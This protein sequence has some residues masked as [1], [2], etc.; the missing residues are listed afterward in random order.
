MNI[1]EEIIAYKKNEVAQQKTAMRVEQLE[2]FGFFS[3]PCLSLKAS[4]LDKNKTGII[5]EFKRRSPSKGIINDNADVFEVTRAYTAAGASG[6]SVLTDNK[7]FGGSTDDL[8]KARV[9]GIP[10]LRKD[11]MIDEYQLVEAKALGA[12]VILLIAACLSPE[13]V[14]E[15]ATRAKQ[16]GMEVLLEIHAEEELDHLC[17]E[18]DMVGV[19]NRNLKTFTVDLEQSIRLSESIGNSKLRVAESGINS[20]Q[21][22]RYLQ[23]HGFDGFLIGERFMK[24]ADP[25]QAFK[26]FAAQL[27]DT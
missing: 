23:Q 2:Q 13:K 17:D 10:V 25:G 12:D 5:T 22:I 21:N 19:N 7:F 4:L 14:R 20:P 3:E 8:I 24:E 6:L 15:L 27:R 26:E 16:L 18:V 9:N 1:L 11:F